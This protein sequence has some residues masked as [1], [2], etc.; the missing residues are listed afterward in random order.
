M[1]HFFQNAWFISG[2]RDIPGTLAHTAHDHNMEE[3]FLSFVRLIST[4]Y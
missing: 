2:S 1:K 3:G 4:V